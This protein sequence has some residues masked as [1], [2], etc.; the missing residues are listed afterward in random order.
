MSFRA[1]ASAVKRL[2]TLHSS[3]KI[4]RALRLCMLTSQILLGALLI[5]W[6][7]NTFKIDL[8]DLAR[9]ASK[10]DYISLGLSVIC[11]LLAILCIAIRYKLFLPAKVSLGYMVGVALLQQAFLNFLPL[12][13]GEVSYPVVLRRDHDI[14]LASSVVMLLTVRLADLGVIL[15]VAMVA[16]LRFGI[17]VRLAALILACGLAVII[18][19]LVVFWHVWPERLADLGQ[20]LATF[21]RPL[22]ESRRLSIFIILTV[23]NFVL[24]VT[25][26]TLALQALGLPLPPLDVAAFNAISLLFALLPI[27][28]P[29]G[30]GTA[31]ALQVFLL[32]RLGY[33][34]VTATPI[35]LT[36][37]SFFTILFALGGLIGWFIRGRMI[38]SIGSGLARSAK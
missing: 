16:S 24:A 2:S 37:H 26:T 31:D 3:P 20:S 5:W 21:L 32:E 36:A 33:S 11:F 35:I 34:A 25:Q 15:C 10:G 9:Q 19:G 13:L 7:T 23:A 6:L 1:F 17:D 29:G 12:R 4:A 18:V 38:A 22:Q 14:S 28:P 30:W 27:H 8:E